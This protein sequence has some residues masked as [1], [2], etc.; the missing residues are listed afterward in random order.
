MASTR[1]LKYQPGGSGCSR[2]LRTVAAFVS[3]A[4]CRGHHRRASLACD[5]EASQVDLQVV[6]CPRE[7]A[8]LDDQR[9]INLHAPKRRPV[10]PQ[11]IRQDERVSPIVLRTRDGVAIPK[12][13][14]LLRIDRKHGESELRSTCRPMRLEGTQSP[15]ATRCSSPL[16]RV[17]SQSTNPWTPAAVCSISRC[18]RPP[19]SRSTRHAW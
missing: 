9:R 14:E 8:D 1:L 3:R 5:S 13:I 7:R 19:P 16:A 10:S 15:P 18:S 11:R 17:R 2:P 6:L 4:P 12:A